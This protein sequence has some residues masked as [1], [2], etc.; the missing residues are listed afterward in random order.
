MGPGARLVPGLG[1]GG[2]CCRFV[3]RGVW[4][5]LVCGFLSG[6]RAEPCVSAVL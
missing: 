2:G 6:S 1:G 5:G 4:L 3:V